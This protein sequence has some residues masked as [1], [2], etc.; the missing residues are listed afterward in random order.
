MRRTT[1]LLAFAALL[2]A[3]PNAFAQGGAAQCKQPVKLSRDQP[4]STFTLVKGSYRVTVR[5]TGDLTCDEARQ[6]F[7]EILAAPG[8][9]LPDDWDV[10]P[11]G[12]SFA[13][14]DGSDVFSVNR[15]IP[16]AGGGGGIDW[17]QIQNLAV[18]WLPIVFLGIV[19][20]G[21]L[22]MLRFMSQSVPGRNGCRS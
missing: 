21:L 17:A 3:A 5:E 15:V 16:P 7:R 1:L 18:L 22:W 13:R 4:I 6:Y 10:D 20:F 2:C 9:K 19:A 12:Q 8:G 11:T 14:G